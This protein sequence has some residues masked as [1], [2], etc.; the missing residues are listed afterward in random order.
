[1]SNAKNEVTRLLEAWQA[2]DEDALNRLI[3]LIEQELRGLARGF[4]SRERGHHTLQPTALVNEV[5]IKLAQPDQVSWKNRA[6]FLGF[7]AQTMRRVLTDHARRH[8]AQIRN[9]GVRP[10]PL[11]ELRDH[12]AFRAQDL[13]DLDDALKELKELEPKHSYALELFYFAGLKYQEVG[14][15]MDCSEA[16]AKRH[17]QKG[18]AWLR[19]YFRIAEASS[20]DA[21]SSEDQES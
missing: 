2:G 3:P 15:V 12:P 9:E 6:H 21:G 11:D 14:E 1:M 10:M 5:F 8:K 4:M 13:V 7:A 19:R 18:R 20:P 17:L 16:T